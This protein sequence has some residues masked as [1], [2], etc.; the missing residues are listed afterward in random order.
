MFGFC[1][2]HILNTGCA[3]IWKKKSVAKRLITQRQKL[4]YPDLQQPWHSLAFISINVTS[5]W[6]DFVKEEFVGDSIRQNQKP[7][8]TTLASHP[9][10]LDPQHVL[11]ISWCLV[12]LPSDRFPKISPTNITLAVREILQR[13][14]TLTIAENL[15]TSLSSSTWNIPN[16]RAIIPL[17]LSICYVRFSLKVTDISR[18]NYPSWRHRKGL[19]PV[20]GLFFITIASP[21]TRRSLLYTRPARIINTKPSAPPN[22]KCLLHTHTRTR[23]NRTARCLSDTKPFSAKLIQVPHIISRT[24]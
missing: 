22:T 21:C 1:I 4:S 23:T 18:Q 2:T 10:N 9:Q 20:T 3:K 15:H 14:T 7:R 13:F 6:T 8:P 11:M 12:N 5:S 16:E 19:T 24:V 17:L